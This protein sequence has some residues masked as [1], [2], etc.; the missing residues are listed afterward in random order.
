VDDDVVRIAPAAQGVGAS[1]GGDEPWQRRITE[2]DAAGWQQYVEVPLLQLVFFALALVRTVWRM[3]LYHR[4]HEPR[5][6]RAGL[7]MRLWSE[8]AD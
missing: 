1:P 2:V 3:P 6:G 7:Q 4:M 8:F 5:Q